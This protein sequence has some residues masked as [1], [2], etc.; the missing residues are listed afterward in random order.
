MVAN[1]TKST[2]ARCRSRVEPGADGAAA[3]RWQRMLWVMVGTQF[4]MTAAFSVLSPT[5]PLLLPELG[6]ETA[7]AVDLRAGVLDGITSFCDV[8]F[9]GVATG[10]RLPW[11]QV[12]TIALE[13]RHRRIDRLDGHGGECPAIPCVSRAGGAVLRIFF[14][15]LRW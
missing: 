2:A 11:P 1:E 3:M 10:Y 4:I 12:D 13:P 8:R 5:M 15:P 9:A 7:S 6:V 14:Q